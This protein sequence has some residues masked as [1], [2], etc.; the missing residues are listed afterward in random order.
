M[1]FGKI[2]LAAVALAGFVSLSGAASQAQPLV[3]I[4]AVSS[5]ADVT[6]AQY[7]RPDH[8]FG[9]PHRVC[10]WDIETKRIRGR[11]VRERVQ[12]CKMVRR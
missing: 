6:F 8:R 7:H 12:R 9:R 5:K 3:R 1:T 2:A 4:P 11:V 10:R